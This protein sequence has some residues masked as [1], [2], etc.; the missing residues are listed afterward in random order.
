MS[1]GLACP[2][3][4]SL[5]R[6][7]LGLIA[8]PDGERLAEHLEGCPHC[9]GVVATLRAEDTLTEAVSGPST[10][11]DSPEAV[12]VR[13][14]IEPVHFGGP[15]AGL[16]REIAPVDARSLLPA[17]GPVTIEPSA[18]AETFTF[19][20]PP[21][22]PGEIGRL[23]QYRVV[24]TL[25]VGGMGIVFQAEDV[26]L[27][28]TV[29]LKVMNPEMADR[30]GARHRFLREAQAAAVLEHENIITIYQVGEERGVPFLA[31]PLLRGMSL[32]DRLTRGDA[33]SIS[34]VLRLG[35]QVALGLAAAHDRGLVHRDIK[36]ANLWLEE[37]SGRSGASGAKYRVRI[38]DFGLA[39]P[40]QED[41]QVT[42]AGAILGTP[43]YM[44]PE[45]GRGDP[46]D[47]RC[48]LFSL[49]V[50]LYQ[51]CSGK[52]PFRGDNPMAVLFA[53]AT[54]T[55][56]QVSKLNPAVPAALEDLVMQLLAK[57]PANRPA[58]AKVV[59]D[60]LLA[61]ARQTEESRTDVALPE[62]HSDKT[63]PAAKRLQ[64][65]PSPAPRPVPEPVEKKRRPVT[66][67][68]ASALGALAVL[69][70]GAIFFLQTPHGTV[71][72]EINDPTIQAVLTGNG[73]I[74]KGADKAQDIVVASGEHAL[75]IK[76]GDL[77][78]ESDKFQ[79]K[80]GDTV[81]LR[82]ELLPGRVRVVQ[83]DK[84]IGEKELPPPAA[85]ERKIAEAVL[86]L[87]GKIKLYH[88]VDEVER[89]FN[90]G[91]KVPEGDWEV[92]AIDLIENKKVTNSNLKGFA[93]LKNLQWL[94]LSLTQVTDTGLKELAGLNGLK[95]LFLTWMRVSD[96]GLKNMGLANHKDMEYLVLGGIGLT[97]EG[98]KDVAGLTNLT[99]L[100]IYSTG[101]T[102][103]GL[104]QL[105]GLTKLTYLAVGIHAV[106]D[107]GLK[108][109]PNF[110]N[111]DRLDIDHTQ[112]T[113]A[114][115][116]ELARFPK[117]ASLS[118]RNTQVTDAGIKHLAK[119]KSLD[120]VDLIGTK[121]TDAGVAEL[122]KSLPKCKIATGPAPP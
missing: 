20:A 30:P 68:I 2:D 76:R 98:L 29:A 8:D 116:T 104:K 12:D 60:R 82:V 78:F 100:R 53:L 64:P 37:L 47:H 72:I 85:D 80:K 9:T 44:A 26:V 58:S 71:R 57:D 34:T 74:I 81:A 87:G 31:M 55:P 79:V 93:G 46:V 103:E 86:A 101:V 61:L 38:L 113:D 51:M 6:L 99:G 62:P 106:T 1:I 43:A 77:E 90:P 122:Q 96:V 120:Y 3:R 25:G 63:A 94:D 92:R 117:L 69:I 18:G 33:L 19:L 97:D 65:K 21:K 15:R 54:E 7:L 13:K 52:K 108:N 66:L 115:L 107:A 42:Q 10:I 36:P 49:G 88:R 112:I 111:L 67:M 70:A 56:T 17:D 23:G 5:H 22:G 28:R 40:V 91:D 119:L 105:G 84:A 39:R 50:V 89:Q 110:N 118:L 102:D 24:R 121:V 75:K 14:S 95:S 48:D 109:L 35:R 4:E 83:G 11:G 114:G 32:E 27:K 41:A 16:S 45:Q 73:A 59:A